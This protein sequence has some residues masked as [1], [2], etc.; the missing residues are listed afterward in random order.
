MA[1]GEDRPI[2]VGGGPHHITV[3]LPDPTSSSL[4]QEFSVAPKDPAIP[5]K[6]IVITDGANEV[7]RWPLSDGWKIT[8]V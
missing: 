1:A 2:V 4:P 7:F 3:Q 6:E 5:F 8:I